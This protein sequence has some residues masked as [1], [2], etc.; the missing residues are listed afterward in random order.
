[1]QTTFRVYGVYS[2]T[3]YMCMTEIEMRQSYTFL[4]AACWSRITWREPWRPWCVH[5]NEDTEGDDRG[6]IFW[7]QLRVL[8]GL[9]QFLVSSE[10]MKWVK[11]IYV[12]N[13]SKWNEAVTWGPFFGQKYPFLTL[14]KYFF[15]TEINWNTYTI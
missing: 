3:Q 8:P 14:K 9:W 13:M 15:E 2:R 7:M 11:T 10:K 12:T 6:N 1:M 4:E 5:F